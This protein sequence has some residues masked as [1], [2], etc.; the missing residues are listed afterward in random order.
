MLKCVFFSPQSVCFTHENVLL[1][2]NI[3]IKYLARIGYYEFK[4]NILNYSVLSSYRKV[5]S[6]CLPSE[7]TQDEQKAPNPL[8]HLSAA[9][10]GEEV[11]PEAVPFHRRARRVLQFPQLDGDP[12]QNLVSEQESQS[13][14]AAGGRT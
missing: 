3:Y 5:E 13:Q 7:E 8:H 14:A 2:S 10:P 9:G 11:P 12:G 6:S 1:N 4:S